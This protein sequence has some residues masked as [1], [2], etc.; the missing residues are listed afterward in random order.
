MSY[1]IILKMYMYYMALEEI[2][3]SEKITMGKSY[4][5]FLNEISADDLFEGLLGYG[6]FA[7]KL[8]PCFTSEGLCQ[9][10]KTGKGEKLSSV[11]WREY[12]V[13]DSQRNT[14]VPRR[15]GIPVPHAYY[16]LCK[17]LSGSWE[18]IRHHMVHA[19]SGQDYIVSRIHLRKRKGDKALF[20]MN[21]QNWKVDGNPEPDLLLG[22]KYIVKSD[23]S[24]CFPSIYTHSIPWALV[25]KEKSKQDRKN[26]QWFN[27]IDKQC[28]SC[29]NGET[30]GLLIG[31]H[32]SNLISE[33][34]LTQVDRK[35]YSNGWRY[36]RA[37]DDFTCYVPSIEKG[38]KFIRELR[39]ELAYYDL[40]LNEKKTA[41][42]ELPFAI[43][44]EWVQQLR[45]VQEIY[46]RKE[47]IRY[48][49]VA[50]YLASAISVMEENNHDGA[51][52][53]YVMKVLS[54]KKMTEPAR[55]YL[56]KVL[57]HMAYL[58][59]YLVHYLE[60]YIFLPYK[61]S[62][63]QIQDFSNLLYDEGARRDQYEMMYFALYFAWIYGFEIY[64]VSAE[65][66][67]SSN[68]CICKVLALLYFQSIHQD[69]VLDMLRKHAKSFLNDDGDFDRNWLFA[70]EALNQD[71]LK[72]EWKAYKEAGVTFIKK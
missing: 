55:D 15:F 51:P 44:H 41:I 48:P 26:N 42:R 6:L 36:T 8:P 45:N 52:I 10:Y 1:V 59:P 43:N 12:I 61:V 65:K 29:T 71:Q 17:A 57:L 23:I 47:I 14:M 68:S 56:V 20:S 34:I 21:Y 11:N 24:T 22:N 58:Y 49:D 66:I 9:F 25:G 32:A 18:K 13:F 60:E 27:Q 16:H 33:I 3:V 67:I 28:Q 72:N 54:G 19:V 37:I 35:L 5:D 69:K 50:G 64:N 4:A 30:H 39:R 63:R 62:T 70:Y 31:P 53:N 46:C 7:N 40:A 38:E 2:Q